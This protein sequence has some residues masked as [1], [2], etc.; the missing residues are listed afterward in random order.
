MKNKMRKIRKNLSSYAQSYDF[1]T[2]HW[3]SNMLDRLMKRMDRHLFSSGNF[4]GS[5]DTANRTIRAW[6]LILNFAPSNPITRKKY[7]SNYSSP[8]ARLNQFSYHES[9]LQNLLISASMGGYKF[10]PL[11]PWQLGYRRGE[12]VWWWKKSFRN[13]ASYRCRHKRIA[14]HN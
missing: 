4:H 9:W 10:V 1:P 3:T 12:R 7:G 14:P 5:F 6:A 8:V 2:S 13:Q 11:N